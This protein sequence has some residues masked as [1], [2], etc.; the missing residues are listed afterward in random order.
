M[1]KRI[2]VLTGL[3]CTIIISSGFSAETLIKTQDGFV[4]IECV[5]VGTTVVGCDEDNQ[6]IGS[7]VIYKSLHKVPNGVSIEIDDTSIVT[8]SDQLF[9]CVSQHEW[10]MAKDLSPGDLLLGESHTPIPVKGV[11]IIDHE[12]ILYNIAV[13]DCHNFLVLKN[14]ILVHNFF[15]LFA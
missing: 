8:S 14:G 3:L 1:V 2:L 12:L 5:P 13:K 4:P 7:N 9:Y 15:R 11:T 10:K 6:Y